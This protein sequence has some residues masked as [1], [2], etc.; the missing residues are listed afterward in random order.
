MGED[1][2]QQKM[3]QTS[4]AELD[5]QTRKKRR[6]NPDQASQVGWREGGEKKGEREGEREGKSDGGR[7]GVRDGRRER[8]KEGRE[9]WRAVVRDRGGV[10]VP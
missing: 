6:K 7:E 4:A 10:V 2:E 5:R 3:L 1:Y 8:R 9:G